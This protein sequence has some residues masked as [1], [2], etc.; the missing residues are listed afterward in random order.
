MTVP[1]TDTKAGTRLSYFPL[2]LHVAGKP[3][4]V[5]GSTADSLAKVRLLLKSRAVLQVFDDSFSPE[6]LRLAAEGQVTLKTG[7]PGAGDISAAVFGYIGYADKRRRD[8]ALALFQRGAKLVCV[9]D[10]KERSD[11]ITPAIIDRAP[12][13]VAIGSEGQGPV[14]VRRIKAMIERLLPS[15]AGRLLQLAGAERTLAAR[16]PKGRV[17]RRFWTQM[18]DQLGPAIL[19]GT[20]THKQP[21]AFAA[22]AQKLVRDLL[23][24]THSASLPVCFVSAGPGDAGHLTRAA[25]AAL[26]DAD[27]IIH[28]RLVAPSVLEL[29]R[30]E[31]NFINVG[32]TGFGASFKQ[33]A[34]NDL[35][36][37]EAKK[38]RQ[39]V[40]LKGGDA[41]LFGRLDEEIQALDEAQLPF[42]I[43][44]GV[45]AASALAAEMGVS[46]SQRGRNRQ[47]SFITG[48]Q[49]GGYAEHEWRHLASGNVVTAIYMGRR[50]AAYL[51]GRLLMFGGDR[52]MPVTLAADV[53]SPACTVIPSDLGRFADDLESLRAGGPV[54][55]ILG[56]H[57][58][59]AAALPSAAVPAR[60]TARNSL[61]AEG[62]V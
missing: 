26:H 13:T 32:K 54:V 4:I 18:F 9:I 33:E 40:R 17:R 14:L 1:V 52:Q 20:P 44:P 51:Q 39:V 48:Y 30:R 23:E 16:L 37:A 2:Q 10:D 6:F 50:A 56:L 57:P 27:V 25:E 41:C 5:C 38:G 29:C 19:R 47:V 43:I 53:A 42:R 60:K 34:I 36:V 3:V 15:E 49:L 22:A 59:K 46:L 21:A 12:L 7:L 28:D 45:T 61:T 55:I 11:F 58:H 31:A 35:L 62:A 24:Q 8:Q